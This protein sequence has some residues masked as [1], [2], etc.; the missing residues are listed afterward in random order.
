M[1]KNILA[2]IFMAARIKMKAVEFSLFVQSLTALNVE[3]SQLE[4][5]KLMQSIADEEDFCN[6]SIRTIIC[7]LGLPQ[8]N[9]Q[10][11]GLIGFLLKELGLAIFDINKEISSISKKDVEFH[12]CP[13]SVS[14]GQEWVRKVRRR[15]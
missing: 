5:G 8:S 9:E 2:A 11:G 10:I 14:D 6:S 1:E 3:Y 12:F 7:S 4:A 15:D 13:T